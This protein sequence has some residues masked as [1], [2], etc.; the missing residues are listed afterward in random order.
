MATVPVLQADRLAK[1]FLRLRPSQT[2]ISIRL[3]DQ[4]GAHITFG[5][6]R[7]ETPM[8]LEGLG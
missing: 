3:A 6:T 8:I 1:A 4:D 5:R 7:E 2:P